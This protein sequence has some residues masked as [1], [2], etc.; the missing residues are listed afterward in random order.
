MGR[1]EGAWGTGEQVKSFRT[2]QA[3]TRSS[4]Q[5]RCL[6]TVLLSRWDPWQPPRGSGGFL[7]L[8][9]SSSLDRSLVEQKS[10][11]TSWSKDLSN[12]FSH[13]ED[14]VWALD[15]GSQAKPERSDGCPP[16]HLTPGWGSKHHC[17]NRDKE[18]SQKKILQHYSSH[19]GADGDAKSNYSLCCA[20]N[21]S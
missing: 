13:R 16:A 11:I 6:K 14:E 3:A 17:G 21:S 5:V 19:Y 1:G 12:P 9:P 2:G 10:L 18:G 4:C 8:L 20:L 7:N 15:L